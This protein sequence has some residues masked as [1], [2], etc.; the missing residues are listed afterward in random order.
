[1]FYTYPLT[2]IYLSLG[3]LHIRA[4]VCTTVEVVW[5]ESVLEIPLSLY[6]CSPLK[7]ALFPHCPS[8]FFWGVCRVRGVA[9][10]LLFSQLWEYLRLRVSRK[11]ESISL[12]LSGS[13]IVAETPA[14]AARAGLS[15]FPSY[16]SFYVSYLSSSKSG[17]FQKKKK[18]I[19]SAI[20]NPFQLCT[21]AECV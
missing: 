12:G 19:R 5:K 14:V 17:S 8:G 11:W 20:Q 10:L 9:E 7:T 6:L 21:I 16:K 18:K 13:Y 3:A 1:M 15:L 4:R 2:S